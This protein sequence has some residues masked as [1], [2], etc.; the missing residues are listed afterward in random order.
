MIKQPNKL[1]QHSIAKYLYVPTITITSQSVFANSIPTATAWMHK[2]SVIESC[3]SCT[4]D[5]YSMFAGLVYLILAE[6]HC[7]PVHV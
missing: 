5:Q 1:K 7:S 4:S 2:E 3:H 6:N